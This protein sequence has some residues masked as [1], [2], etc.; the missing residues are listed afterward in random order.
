MISEERDLAD[1]I[2]VLEKFTLKELRPLLAYDDLS[3]EGTKEEIIERFIEAGKIEGV[4]FMTANLT[5]LLFAKIFTKCYVHKIP[6]KATRK[7]LEDRLCKFLGILTPI[8]AEEWRIVRM[9]KSPDPNFAFLRDR[10]LN[11]KGTEIEWKEQK[12]LFADAEH[13]TNWGEMSLIRLNLFSDL[14]DLGVHDSRSVAI[15][16][17]MVGHEA[18][19]VQYKSILKEGWK[20]GRVG[21]PKRGKRER[22]KGKHLGRVW[23]PS[24]WPGSI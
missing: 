24:S 14:Y 7:E 3:E 6:V 19:M 11:V 23:I 16:A 15:K 9:D 13:A 5:D 1:Y 10:A 17:L 4:D 22:C 20:R 21:H 8:E 12:E 18:Y 2:T